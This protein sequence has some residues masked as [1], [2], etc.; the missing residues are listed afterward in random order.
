MDEFIESVIK[1]ILERW[2]ELSPDEKKKQNKKQN[3]QQ[4]REKLINTFISF[5]GDG[6]QYDKTI[7]CVHLN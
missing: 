6:K 3:Q 2:N 1:T 7:I 5:V 4:Q